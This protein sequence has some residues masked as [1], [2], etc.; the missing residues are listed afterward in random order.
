MKLFAVL[1]ISSEGNLQK[2]L[3]DENCSLKKQNLPFLP[4][5]HGLKLV[6]DI[7]PYITV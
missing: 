7:I 3:L 2:K 5:I 4:I 6:I 1:R